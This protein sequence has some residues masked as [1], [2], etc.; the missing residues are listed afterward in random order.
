MSSQAD[1][2]RITAPQIQARK[3]G[4]PIVSLTSYHSHT[5]RLLDRHVDV[6]LV[7]DSLGMV[8]HG[9]ETTVP[10]TVEMMIVHGRAVVR[11]TKRALIVVDLPFGSYEAS[12]TEA[13]HT[14]ARVL[15]ETGAGAVKLEGG[16]RMA[17]TV[18]F[19]VDRGVPVMGHVGL[20]PQAINTLGSF[21]ARGRDDAEASIILDDARAIAEAGAF[22]IVL[23]A[24]AEPLARRITQEVAPPTIGIGGSPACDG[25][26][27][28]LEDM[29]G[30]G[31]RVPKFVKKYA[32]LGPDIE[33][34]V[35]SYADEVR[36]RTFP[37]AEHTYA[38][39]LV[40]KPAKAS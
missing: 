35:A 2:R 21:K 38:P 25:Q 19:L 8:M 29:L 30:L 39:R 26:I 27:L 34:A 33:K 5:A 24:I 22:S 11:G 12:H 37:A 18:R 9:M 4:E 10:V 17:E 16:R 36:A 23:E 14:A 1:A 6:I 40:E 31:D 13:F 7:G 32:N 20:T 28:V 15:K 3:G